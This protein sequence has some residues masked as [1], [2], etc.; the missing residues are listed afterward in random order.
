MSAIARGSLSQQQ[1]QM[2]FVPPANKHE[3]NNNSSTINIIVVT[4]EHLIND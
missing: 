1:Y 2:A 4:V 3:T